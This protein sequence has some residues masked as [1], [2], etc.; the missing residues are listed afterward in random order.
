METV[1]SVGLRTSPTL[2]PLGHDGLARL[3]AQ[4]W[5]SP[6]PR[7]SGPSSQASR[8]ARRVCTCGHHDHGRRGGAGATGGLGKRTQRPKHQE[9]S[10]RASSNVSR[11][12]THRNSAVTAGRRRWDGTMAPIS[13]RGATVVAYGGQKARETHDTLGFL[14]EQRERGERVSKADKSTEFL[15]LYCPSRQGKV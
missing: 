8:C 1:H 10:G 12:G 13:G 2:R 7:G 15:W 3:A 11:L 9:D 5:G 14:E 6:W 4:G